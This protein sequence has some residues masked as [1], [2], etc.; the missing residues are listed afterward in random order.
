MKCTMLENIVHLYDFEKEGKRIRGSQ[1]F[2][3]ARAV[4]KS[5]FVA[6]VPHIATGGQNYVHSAIRLLAAINVTVNE[7]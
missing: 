6:R 3:I 1:K 7:R 4:W 2:W 5:V